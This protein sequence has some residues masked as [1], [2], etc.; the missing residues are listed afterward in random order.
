MQ[1]ARALFSSAALEDKRPR[2]PFDLNYWDASEG[3]STL[4][5]LDNYLNLSL[6]LTSSAD[7]YEFRR[8]ISYFN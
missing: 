5:D 1:H 4:N 6:F 8:D 7:Y 3:I 2:K